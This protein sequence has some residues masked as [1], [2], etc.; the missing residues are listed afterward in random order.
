MNRNV[1]RRP[2]I[3]KRFEPRV[4]K[5]NDIVGRAATFKQE[6]TQCTF[7]HCFIIPEQKLYVYAS[8]QI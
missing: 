2:G 5:L 3:S 6:K 8:E 1:S 7:Q 4:K